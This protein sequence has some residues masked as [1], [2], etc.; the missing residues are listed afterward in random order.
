MYICVAKRVCRLSDRPAG[1]DLCEPS[2]WNASG[3]LSIAGEINLWVVVD[4]DESECQPDCDEVFHKLEGGE[5]GLYCAEI[6][7]KTYSLLSE[8][9]YLCLSEGEFYHWSLPYPAPFRFI[10]SPASSKSMSVTSDVESEIEFYSFVV[11]NEELT[12]HYDDI[13]HNFS[14]E[15]ESLNLSSS[16]AAAAYQ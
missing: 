10:P 5:R 15:R 14:R 12:P 1:C 8:K 9:I 7:S 16:A 6:I 2:K 13:S 4:K 3:W 11:V